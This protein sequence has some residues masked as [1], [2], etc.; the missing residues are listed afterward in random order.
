VRCGHKIFLNKIQDEERQLL[1]QVARRKIREI[2]VEKLSKNSASALP[3]TIS[4]QRQ[5]TEDRKRCKYNKALIPN[6]LNI[7]LNYN[8]YKR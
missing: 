7:A 4:D 6:I 8:A 1:K 2:I 5:S 3:S